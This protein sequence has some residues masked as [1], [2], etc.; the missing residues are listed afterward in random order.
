MTYGPNDNYTSC[1]LPDLKTLLRL[2]CPLLGGN[3]S[4]CQ[5]LKTQRLQR[6]SVYRLTLD[7]GG[8]IRTIVLKR[9]AQNFS[10]IEQC[11][12][13]RWLTATDLSYI[14]P[15]LYCAIAEQ[16][17]NY[18]WHVYE[19]LGDNALDQK[20]ITSQHTAIKDRGFLSPLQHKS[21]RDHIAIII[22]IIAEVHDKFQ[23]HALLGECRQ[24]SNDL[25]SHFLSTS[26]R[27]TIRAFNYLNA[28]DRSYT[29]S[30]I[31][32]L[33]RLLDRL[34]TFSLQLESRCDLLE[35]TGGQETLLH[36]DL[37][38]K[39]TFVMHT[40]N[41]LTGRL[42]DWDHVGVG[43][44][45]YDLSTFLMQ[46]PIDDRVWALDLYKSVRKNLLGNWPAYHEWNQLFETNEYARLANCALWPAVALA[47]RPCDWAFDDLQK[48]E[49]WF[50][51]L[52]PVLPI[53]K[54]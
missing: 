30:Q 2:I 37:G 14:S 7:I 42:I 36:G 3:S 1:E 9:F 5:F 41:G 6:S 51:R 44:V 21:E 4:N 18:L 47:E 20:A 33:D 34:K 49:D 43:P 54:E 11:C 24:L 46:L 40:A 19:D 31:A 39:N 29:T 50:G 52:A 53:D 8:A 28:L 27:D 17:G 10:F 26:M 15:T 35:K 12:I 22:K 13:K 32:L 25:G 38:V 48:I 16:T 45:C 23:G